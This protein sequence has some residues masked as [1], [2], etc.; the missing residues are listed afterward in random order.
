GMASAGG[1]IA[2]VGLSGAVRALPQSIAYAYSEKDEP[3]RPSTTCRAAASR[4]TF[5][6]RCHNQALVQFDVGMASAGGLIAVVGLSGAV[7]ALPQS[8]AYAYSEKDEPVRPS[9]TCR[10]AAS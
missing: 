7:R 5:S 4:W 8:I 10:A 6:T 1:L 2:V 3:V 9:T